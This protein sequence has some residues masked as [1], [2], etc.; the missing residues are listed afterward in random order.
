MQ[1]ATYQPR[2]IVQDILNLSYEDYEETI[3]RFIDRLRRQVR[4]E[5]AIYRFGE[6]RTPGISDIDLL[7]I[8]EDQEW[9][10]AIQFVDEI[11][12]S[13]ELSAYLFVHPPLVIGSSLSPLIPYFHTIQN[14][15]LV[16]EN[17]QSRRLSNEYK[18]QQSR[19]ICLLRHA[20]WSSYIRV[21]ALE[22]NDSDVGL[23]RILL[24]LNNLQMITVGANE[25]L[26]HPLSIPFSTS[27]VRDSVLEKGSAFE[28]CV[29]AHIRK[30]LEWMNVVEAKLD[31][32][33]SVRS[34]AD[35]PGPAIAALS[36]RK[37]IAAP[38]TVPVPEY[39]RGWMRRYFDKV[40]FVKVP[41][42]LIAYLS[43]FSRMAKVEFPHTTGKSGRNTELG[44]YANDIEQFAGQYGYAK[45]LHDDL[46][47]DFSMIRPFSYG[48]RSRTNKAKIHMYIKRIIIANSIERQ[49]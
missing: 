29:R 8:V 10:A 37:Y 21:A 6:I 36:P 13:S 15:K 44:E 18:D 1:L 45:K 25:F 49:F 33:L 27:T 31:E 32:Q 42:Y 2:S 41:R 16:W 39:G 26:D 22:I 30:T 43:S 4:G 35:R 3:E 24:L 7:V 9:K 48:S 19:G 23:R 5:L 28:V 34:E 40:V 47:V 38:L 20:L 14:C 46:G 17:Y 11:V 12:R